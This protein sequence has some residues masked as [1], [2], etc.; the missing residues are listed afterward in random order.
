MKISDT[1]M[2]NASRRYGVRLGSLKCE[3]F[4]LF[5][6][7]FSVSEVR[8]LLGKENSTEGGQ[9]SGETVRRYRWSWKKKSRKAVV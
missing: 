9:I 2:I 8:Y 7:G 3:A 4:C 1:E 6:K 5:D